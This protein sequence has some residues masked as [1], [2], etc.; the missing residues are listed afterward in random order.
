ML[1]LLKKL[2]Y[3]FS[4]YQMLNFDIINKMSILANDC[5]LEILI[6]SDF[7][8]VLTI[9]LINKQL[10]S[11]SK[12]DVIWKSQIDVKLKELFKLDTY[13]ETFRKHYQIKKIIKTFNLNLDVEEMYDRKKLYLN[14]N[15]IKEIPKEI[16][17][18]INLQHLFLSN[19]QIKEIPKEI[20]NLINLQEL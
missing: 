10:N 12:N 13:F 3:L 2:I 8:T 4:K 14:D 17:N 9:K 7:H 1:L 20:G 5:F 19:N 18:L 11:I 6:H 16:G 15:Q